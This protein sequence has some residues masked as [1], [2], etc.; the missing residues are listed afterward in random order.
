MISINIPKEKKKK[1]KLMQIN[2]TLSTKPN[3]VSNIEQD[4]D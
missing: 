2:G 4:S 3:Q 1:K